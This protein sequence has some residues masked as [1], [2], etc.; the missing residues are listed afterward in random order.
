MQLLATLQQDVALRKR[1]RRLLGPK[2]GPR[3]RIIGAQ[4]IRG[5]W[6][7]LVVRESGHEVIARIN[8]GEVRELLA[9]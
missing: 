1:A 4:K 3:F 7:M 5:Q 6:V 9:A 8:R 2:I